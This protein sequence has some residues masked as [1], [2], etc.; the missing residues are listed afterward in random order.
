MME[1]YR[2]LEAM[3]DRITLVYVSTKRKWED[4]F[5]EQMNNELIWRNHL[6]NQ[7]VEYASSGGTFP[8]LQPDAQFQGQQIG[9]QGV[10]EFAWIESVSELLD[11]DAFGVRANRAHPTIPASTGAPCHH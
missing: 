7:L 11:G 8:S 5:M 6:K 4:E 9:L 10:I 2:R 1:V 3:L